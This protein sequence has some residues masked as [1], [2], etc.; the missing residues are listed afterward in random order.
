ME[1][2]TAAL[3]WCALVNYCIL[4]LWALAF[5]FARGW[6]YRVHSALLRVDIAPERYDMLHLAGMTFYKMLVFV[7]NLTPFLVL[8]AL[9]G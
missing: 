2:L 9:S 1:T 7:F 8:L 6:M 5:V 4:T 3:G